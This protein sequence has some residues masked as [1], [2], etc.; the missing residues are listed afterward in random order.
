MASSLGKMATTSVRRLI[1]PLRRSSGLVECSCAPVV[2][3][4]GHVGEHV[5]LGLVHQL[6]EL[7]EALA[8]AVGDGA[9]LLV[10][11]LG[12]SPA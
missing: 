1:S 11:G 3:G 2:L 9:P 7:A 6:G 10:R 8:Q 5:V 4:E 12:A